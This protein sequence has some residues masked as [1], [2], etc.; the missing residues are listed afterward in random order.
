[1]TEA[2]LK[3]RPLYPSGFDSSQSTSYS[4]VTEPLAALSAGLVMQCPAVSTRSGPTRVTEQVERMKPR[5]ELKST[6][7][8]IP[9]DFRTKL[10]MSRGSGAQLAFS[11]LGG[12][13]QN[14]SGSYFGGST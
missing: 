4:N 9:T 5:V 2:T 10:R 8:I 1:M 12:G 11:Q 13:V 7:R 3:K 14:Q 6:C